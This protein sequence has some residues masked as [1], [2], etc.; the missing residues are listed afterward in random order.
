MK[1]KRNKVSVAFA[2]PLHSVIGLEN[3]SVPLSWP[4]MYKTNRD[5]NF[6][7]LPA[8]EIISLSYRGL[9]ER[10]SF[11]VIGLW[12]KRKVEDSDM[13]TNERLV[14]L[15][16]RGEIFPEHILRTSMRHWALGSRMISAH[17]LII[18]PARVW[19]TDLLVTTLNT[20]FQGFS[21]QLSSVSEEK[22][23]LLSELIALQDNFIQEQCM[24]TV[25]VFL[26]NACVLQLILGFSSL[27]LGSYWCNGSHFES[28]RLCVSEK[29]QH[30]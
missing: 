12:H 29:F 23:I 8:L 5:L 11:V 6:F 24:T 21:T 2:L 3:Q 19:L 1:E 30:T 18:T 17:A 15:L 28:L 13:S 22:G 7:R 20:V 10:F 4:F 26:T 25:L 14:S 9:F 27:L 16:K